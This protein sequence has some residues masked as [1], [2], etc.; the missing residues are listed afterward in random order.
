MTKIPAAEGA[1][2]SRYAIAKST[3]RWRTAS[4]IASA[5][6][7]QAFR[8]KKHMTASSRAAKVDFRTVYN[9]EGRGWNVLTD[10]M[11]ISFT[12]IDVIG[13]FYSAPRLTK[14]NWRCAISELDQ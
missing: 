7:A 5:A 14:T 13:A 11:R 6:I 1:A 8:K 2:K 10:G 12:R 3:L 4:A 9:T